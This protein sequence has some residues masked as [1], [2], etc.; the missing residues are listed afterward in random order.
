MRPSIRSANKQSLQPPSWRSVHGLAIRRARCGSCPWA[1]GKEA[2]PQYNVPCPSI[3]GLGRLHPL[4]ASSL[5]SVARAL[6]SCTCIQSC[7]FRS[8]LMPLIPCHTQANQNPVWTL[9]WV[10]TEGCTL[11]PAHLRTCS[12]LG[13]Q[14]GWRGAQPLCQELL[15]QWVCERRTPG[16]L[17]LLGERHDSGDPG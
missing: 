8:P 2:C 15:S 11:G 10:H 5:I 13:V 12:G 14:Q 17:G 1:V 6:A 7:V 9:K 3:S 4:Q 16:P